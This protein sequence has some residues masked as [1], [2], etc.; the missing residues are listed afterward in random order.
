MGNNEIGVITVRIWF[1]AHRGYDFDMGKLIAIDGNSLMYRAFFALTANAAMTSK[2]G[3]PTGALHGFLGMLINLLNYEPTHMAVAFDMHAPTFR[4]KQ[5]SEYKAGRAP[6]PPELV[7]Q[8]SIIKDILKDMGIAVLECEGFEADDILGTL[9][10]QA[11]QEDLDVLL[12]TGDKDALQLIDDRIHVLMTKKG[13]SDVIEYD[14]NV[15][16]EKYRLQPERM[17]DLK[18]LMGDSSDNLPGIK[19]VGEKTALKLL[20]KYGT[21]E[22]TLEQGAREEKG[23]LQQ[24]IITYRAD[25]L[26]SFSLGRIDTNAPIKET[27]A[28]CTFEK[29]TMQNALPRLMELQLNSVSKRLPQSDVAQTTKP[30]YSAP[31]NTV[32]IRDMST[33]RDTVKLALARDTVAMTFDGCIT[34]AFDTQTQYKI[35]TEG[36]LL[37]MG[38]DIFEVYRELAPI[39]ESENVG[40][41]LFNAKGVMHALDKH[42]IAVK[43]L[44]FDAMI[45]DYLLHAVRPSNTLSELAAAYHA[46]DPGAGTL[47]RLYPEAVKELKEKN[48]YELYENVELPLIEVLYDMERTGFCVDKEILNRLSDEFAEKRVE[49]ERQIYAISGENFNIQ[50]PKQLSDVLFNKLRLP[51]PKQKTKHGYSTSADVLESYEDEYPIVKLVLEYRFVAKLKST[52]I[53]GLLQQI[54]KTTGRVYTTFNQNVTAT[55]RISSTE[56]N[57]QNIPT[58]TQAGREIRR[59][60]VA[61]AGNSLADA[62]YSQIELRVLAHMSGDDVMISAFRS[63]DDIHARTAAEVFRTRIENVTGEQR[64]A[65]KAVN[66]GIVYGI[67]EF[68]LAKQLGISRKRAGEYIRLYLE[69]YTG[70]S[71]FMHECV[72]NA[73]KTGYA[74]TLSGR[75][76]ELFELKS[77]NFNTR[78]FG[79]RIAMNMP[80]QGTAADII[81]IA[82]VHVYNALKENGLK[83]KLVL[84]IHDELIVDAPQDELEQVKVILQECMENAYSLNVPLIAEVKTGTSWFDTK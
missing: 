32:D 58:R 46:D 23:A 59:A 25:A 49:L 16:F 77:S 55:G 2:D 80:V 48:L 51:P 61:S 78:S 10:R 81:K 15:L 3:T 43:N 24:K 50:S 57:L 18:G 63:G 69:R 12:V 34:L 37:D 74:M 72:E 17:V 5:Y 83:A 76:R 65:A 71:R 21:L 26:M 41:V 73:R 67:S 52:F 4:H 75:R 68:G 44:V 31:V 42:G 9:A 54:N 70:I 29:S 22:N 33:L 35:V 6:T 60:F 64:S 39:F 19:G 47:L 82:M 66:F 1:M 56:P 8:F 11:K 53:D 62:D 28:D 79:E 20:E 40:K 14:K 36:T 27:P 13:I 7:T 30:K 38:L 84:Q 45:A